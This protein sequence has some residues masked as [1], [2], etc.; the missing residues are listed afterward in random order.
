[1]RKGAVLLHGKWDRPDG[2]LQ[3]LADTLAAAGWRMVV[4]RCPWSPRRLY[5]RGFAQALDEIE[6]AV[7]AL[8]GS[9]CRRVLLGGHSLGANAAL[10]AAARGTRADALLMIAPG[11]LP[12]RLA[13]DGLT[14]EA[15]ALARRSA[16]GHRLRL[17]DF[18]QGQQRELRFDPATWLS[19]FDPDG[20]AAMPRA[21]AALTVA[22]PVLWISARRDPL[23]A[24]GRGYAFDR[25]PDD[26]QNAFVE[27]DAGHA[28]APGIAAPVAISWLNELEANRWKS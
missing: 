21:A 28:D 25:L 22:R 9:G 23:A 15:L 7:D 13:A 5:D 27:I 18:N 3:P 6:A 19:Y 4:P 2:A 12:D 11:H 24:I 20:D 8:R 1:M 26:P 16:S 10:A 17:P 14:T